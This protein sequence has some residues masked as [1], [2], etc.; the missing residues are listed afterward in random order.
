MLKKWLI[1]ELGQE[2]YKISLVPEGKVVLNTH[3][4]SEQGKRTRSQL[5]ELPTTKARTNWVTK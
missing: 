5:R 2:I 4:Q 3:T 1:L